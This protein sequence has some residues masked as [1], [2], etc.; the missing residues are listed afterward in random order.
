MQT[1]LTGLRSRIETVI[2]HVPEFAKHVRRLHTIE[3]Q[4]GVVDQIKLEKASATFVDTS[5]DEEDS[6][7]SVQAF[8]E[9]LDESCEA[10]HA[11]I[12]SDLRRFH[13]ASRADAPVPKL[14]WTSSDE[15]ALEDF[16]KDRG[17]IVE[18]KSANMKTLLSSFLCSKEVRAKA[19]APHI[20][21]SGKA[22]VPTPHSLATL[23][24]AQRDTAERLIAGRS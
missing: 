16:K 7:G 1:D 22:H 18:L 2:V 4:Q 15:H 20:G 6:E 8:E 10:L 3:Q 5:E 17:S 12:H 21:P 19:P 23:T 24:I 13:G 9:E 11:E 14:V